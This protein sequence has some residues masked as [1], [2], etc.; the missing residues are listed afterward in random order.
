MPQ[1]KPY[2]LIAED[3]IDDVDF[4]TST[5]SNKCPQVL[6]KHLADGQAVLEFLNAC[7]VEELPSLVLI[8]Y[9]M[10]LA[11]AP[12]ILRLLQDED[13]FSPMGKAVWST[14]GRP[15]EIEEC[16]SLG[17]DYFFTK[18]ASEG[19]WEALVSQLRDHLLDANP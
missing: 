8:D 18:P 19:E 14:S 4:F 12:D 2:L 11:S 9:K 10:P 7:P 5:F 16:R 6:V 15:A 17:A 13:R 3:D 1:M